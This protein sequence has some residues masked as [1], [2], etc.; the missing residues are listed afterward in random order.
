MNASETQAQPETERPGGTA[1]SSEEYNASRMVE[2]L[3]GRDWG[4][5]IQRALFMFFFG[6]LA[7]IT[8]S[9]AFFLAAA[10]VVFMIFAGE[11]N[12]ALTRLIKQGGNYIRDVLDYLSFA[13]DECPFPF[14]RNLPDAD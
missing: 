2:D 11:A 13:S 7:W 5:I 10:Q 6:V 14:G 9:V 1:S 12:S 4:Q 3:K 8:L